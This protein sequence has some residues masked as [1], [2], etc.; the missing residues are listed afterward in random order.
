MISLLIQSALFFSF[1]LLLGK[2]AVGIGFADSWSVG[3]SL[4]AAAVFALTVFGLGLWQRRR[5]SRDDSPES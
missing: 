1:S 5:G 3:D 4:F 2:V